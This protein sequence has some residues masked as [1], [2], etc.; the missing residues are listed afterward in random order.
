MDAVVLDA[1][2][3]ACLGDSAVAL[4]ALLL[5][6]LLLDERD[7]CSAVAPRP[8]AGTGF[9]AALSAFELPLVFPSIVA[10]LLRLTF[11]AAEEEPALGGDVAETSASLP[12]LLLLLPL[13]LPPLPHSPATT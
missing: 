5:A 10:P 13:T 9:L 6:L 11:A 4:A 3:R 1:A 8:V 7:T 12:T 2:A